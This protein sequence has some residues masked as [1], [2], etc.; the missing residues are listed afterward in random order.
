MIKIFIF[1]I[2]II[3]YKL[4]FFVRDDELE[5]TD[6]LKTDSILANIDFNS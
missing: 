3:I 6:N 2:L 1:L 4:I 5:D